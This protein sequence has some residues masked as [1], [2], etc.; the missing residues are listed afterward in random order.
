MSCYPI[1]SQGYPPF[2]PKWTI[3]LMHLAKKLKYPLRNLGPWTWP[4]TSTPQYSSYV[5][6]LK[7]PMLRSESSRAKLRKASRPSLLSMALS[8][9][10]LKISSRSRS[11][12]LKKNKR[13]LNFRKINGPGGND[14]WS[15][16]PAWSS[17]SQRMS[18]VPL[19]VT[20]SS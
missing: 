13:G 15:T 20:V 11:T 7:K 10:R 1:S 4:L 18:S 14:R 17:R 5:R 3:P 16:M 2:F 8:R 19:A 6:K 12:L 9:R